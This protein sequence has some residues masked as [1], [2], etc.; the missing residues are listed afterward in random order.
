MVSGF[1]LAALAL[2]LAAC[3]T[4]SP[5]GGGTATPKP[6]ATFAFDLGTPEELIASSQ[7][8]SFRAS[9]GVRLEGRL[10]GEGDVAVV[11]AHMG[12]QD[13]DQSQWFETAG[14]LADQ[15]Y[16]VLTYN[17]RGVCPG[18]DQGCSEDRDDADGWRDLVG[19]VDFLRQ[20]AGSVVIG[21]ASLGAM[22]AMYV[23]GRGEAEI[24]GLIWVA[25]AQG[26]GK[27]D[28]LELAPRVSE[29]KLYLAGEFD[30]E[31]GD[32]AQEL[33][34]A[35]REPK[36]LVLLDTGE[37]GTDIPVFDDPPIADGFRQAILDFLDG[38]FA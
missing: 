16:Q 10:F 31:L 12:G 34:A 7:L 9:D 11:L 36:E 25:G 22:E 8:V 17:R 15:G 32:L 23:A 6:E 30:Q 19:A 21:G 37:H 24:D 20:G 29:P 26:Y 1:R 38:H 13:D 27:A 4:S 33:H 3:S 18:G 35:S 14:L 5:G 2:L 28:L